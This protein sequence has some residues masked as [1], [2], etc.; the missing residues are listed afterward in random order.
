MTSIMFNFSH[1][2]LCFGGYNPTGYNPV[3]RIRSYVLIGYMY[4]CNGLDTETCS[5]AE[6]SHLSSSLKSGLFKYKFQVIPF[7]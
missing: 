6:K 4:S 2:K 7:S 5:L 3:C 1:L